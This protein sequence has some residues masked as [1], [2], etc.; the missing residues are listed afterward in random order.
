M[1]NLPRL[2]TNSR[3]RLYEPLLII[4]PPDRGVPGAS[5]QLHALFKRMVT[6]LGRLL[7]ISFHFDHEDEGHVYNVTIVPSETTC[8]CR[9]KFLASLCGETW[10][11][12]ATVQNENIWVFHTFL[13][14]EKYKWY[15]QLFTLCWPASVQPFF[16]KRNK[17][18]MCFLRVKRN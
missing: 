16:L 13:E 18:S 3:G 12:L 2:V 15:L 14:H 5:G 1:F 6:W 4:Q 9:V 10:F 7:D 11:F 17:C 8:L